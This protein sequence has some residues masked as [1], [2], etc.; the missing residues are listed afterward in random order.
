MWKKIWGVFLRRFYLQAPKHFCQ[1]YW[2]S[3]SK[4]GGGT[5]CCFKTCVRST[6][7]NI[8]QYFLIRICWFSGF[9]VLPIMIFKDCEG[10]KLIASVFTQKSYFYGFCILFIFEPF[11]ILTPTQQHNHANR[12]YIIYF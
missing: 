1:T 10:S 11:I 12:K 2:G 8:I 3:F 6:N 7:I 5:K 4:G 9:Q